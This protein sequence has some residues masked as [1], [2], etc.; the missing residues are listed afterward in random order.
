[1]RGRSE[2]KL[3]GRLEKSPMNL[4]VVWELVSFVSKSKEN[5]GGYL[6][7]SFKLSKAVR[8]GGGS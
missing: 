8:F 4:E 3:G 7:P 6:P 5:N 1:M 2:Y